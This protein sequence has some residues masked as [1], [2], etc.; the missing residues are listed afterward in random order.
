MK[1]KI[2]LSFALLM[3]VA[4]AQAYVSSVSAATGSAGRAAI[5]TLDAPYLNPAALAYNQ[6]YFFGTGY[7]RFRSDG[8]G[9]A[10]TYAIAVT[11][12][13]K[14]TVMP[15]TLAYIDT[16]Y[17][18]GTQNWDRR[19]LRL[20]MGRFVYKRHAL[21]M[22]IDYRNSRSELNGFQQTNLYFGGILASYKELT[23]ALTLDN[24]LAP[25]SSIP[26]QERLNP[27]TALGLSYNYRTFMRAKLD[28]ITEGNNSWGRPTVAGGVESY[29]NQWLIVRIGYSQNFELNQSIASAGLGF[30]GP[31]FGIH[32][33]FQ[34]VQS[35]MG[36]DPRHS[37][38]LAVPIW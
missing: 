25:P 27:A 36:L 15:T 24:V 5:E 31:K 35:P 7:S 3:T 21:G 26:N 17:K 6:G 8:L 29:F 30:G 13:M 9:D 34:N 33:A 22:G 28:L 38:D 14:D 1:T 19:D 11:D 16:K 37:V 18:D 23:L 20:G 10:D 12:N 2:L 32:Y 4:P